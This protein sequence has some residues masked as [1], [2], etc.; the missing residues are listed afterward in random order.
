MKHLTE[1]TPAE[2]ILIVKGKS[3]QKELLKITL[4]D[5][6]LKKVLKIF[7]VEIKSNDRQ[8]AYLYKYIVIDENFKSYLAK[9]HENFFLSAFRQDPKIEIQFKNMVK[10]GFQ[11]SQSYYHF[12]QEIFNNEK[13]KTYISQNFFQKLLA[14]FSL[15]E[16]GTILKRNIETELKYLTDQFSKITNIKDRKAAEM[17]SVFAG[18]IFLIPNINYDFLD[19]MDADFAFERRTAMADASSGCSGWDFNLN[20]YSSDFDSGCSSDSGSS[21]DSGCSSC[22]GCSGCGGCGGCS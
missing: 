16:K 11:N 10:I 6:I 2:A 13:F 17:I 20:D 19:Q 21:G 1:Y 12:K 8:K 7:Q 14:H 22:S 5:L 15:N 3:T 18:S 4:A 9:P